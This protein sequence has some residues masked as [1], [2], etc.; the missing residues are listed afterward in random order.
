MFSE[1]SI[2]NANNV[3]QFLRTAKTNK[4]FTHIAPPEE[5]SYIE[6]FHS[7][8]QGKLLIVLNFTAFMKPNPSCKHTMN[9]IATEENIKDWI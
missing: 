4:E 1:E 3:R 6:A 8:V 9:G 7:I 2:F 5:S